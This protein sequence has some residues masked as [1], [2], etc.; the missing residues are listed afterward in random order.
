MKT[1]FLYMQDDLDYFFFEKEGDYS[2]LHHTF[3]NFEKEECWDELA[4]ITNFLEDTDKLKTPTKD[5]DFF[6]VV[7]HAN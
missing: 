5:W 1:L 7:G 3:F 6:V 2:H 4:H